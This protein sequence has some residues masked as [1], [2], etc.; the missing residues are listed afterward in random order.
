MATPHVTGALAL[1]SAQ[2]PSLSA[3]SLKAS[4]LNNV[5]VLANWNGLVKTG[6]RLNVFKAMQNPTVCDFQFS[7][8][9]IEFGNQ[10]GNGT[11]A[12]NGGDKLRLR[13]QEQR[14]LDHY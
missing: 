6:G 8:T 12:C 5:D 11:S 1:L 13:R 9:T 7:P 14:Q 10:G 2:N 4:L 3:A